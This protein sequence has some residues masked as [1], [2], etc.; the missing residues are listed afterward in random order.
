[1]IVIRTN[2]KYLNSPFRHMIEFQFY[3]FKIMYGHV[4]FFEKLGEVIYIIS[5]LKFSDTMNSST[6]LLFSHYSDDESKAWIPN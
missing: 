3:F 1:M 6:H 2:Y 5:E 4:I